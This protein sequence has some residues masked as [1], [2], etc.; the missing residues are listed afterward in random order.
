MYCMGM[1]LRS[2]SHKRLSHSRSVPASTTP[3]SVPFLLLMYRLMHEKQCDMCT[4]CT[5]AEQDYWSETV[6]ITVRRWSSQLSAECVSMRLTA[7]CLTW[8][9]AIPTV[10]RQWSRSATV[11]QVY[12]SHC[13]ECINL[14]QINLYIQFGSW[15]LQSSD[16]STHPIQSLVTSVLMTELT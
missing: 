15:S 7:G 9:T 4:W 14:P 1:L 16:R 10:E 13:F 3:D 12:V 5:I 8:W 2:H 11:H 6:G